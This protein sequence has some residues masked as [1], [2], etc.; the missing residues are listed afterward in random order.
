MPEGGAIG[1]AGLDPPVPAGH[2]Q[3]V[4]G[5]L[6][7]GPFEGPPVPGS[8]R[9]ILSA[10]AVKVHEACCQD[11]ALDALVADGAVDPRPD[12]WPRHQTPRHGVVESHRN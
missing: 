4:E 1:P 12:D 3:H 6:V 5:A 2:Q 11:H 9:S 7:S 8:I 10:A